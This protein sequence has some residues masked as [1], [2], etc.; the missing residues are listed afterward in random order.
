MPLKTLVKVGNVTN[1]SDARYC[2]GMGVDM[3]GFRV[4]EGQPDYISRT[5]FQ[6]IRGWISGPKVVAEL[7]GMKDSQALTTILADYAPDYFELSFDEY[8]KYA[9]SLTLPVIVR[10]KENELANPV[11][12]QP[13][14]LYVLIDSD[15]PAN[16][17]QQYSRQLSV[18]LDVHSREG[19]Q[20]KLKD[21]PLKGISLSGSAE[22]RPGY[23][24]YE[25]LADVLEELDEY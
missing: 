23:K 11:L 13:G 8:Q 18:L 16:A 17:L 5:L 25:H 4:T 6:E 19:L 15:I 1:L 24:N 2:S 21:Y 3:L 12:Q 20:D 14:V 22:I 10:A 9:A 7:Y